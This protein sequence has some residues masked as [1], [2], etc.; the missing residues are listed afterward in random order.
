MPLNG[1]NILL[2]LGNANKKTEQTNFYSSTPD[3]I[4]FDSHFESGNL[5]YAFRR[6]SNEIETY[7]LIMQ[8]DVNTKGHN[9]WFYFKVTSMKKHNKIKFNI[10]NFIKDQSMFS[11]GIK[12]LTF[13]EK[14]YNKHKIGW[15]RSGDRV[16][17]EENNIKR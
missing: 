7:D 4:R 10:V 11:Y 1:V 12:P 16:S 2:N 13:S 14:N 15:V 5:L 6:E 8:N 17:Y 9:Q 3:S